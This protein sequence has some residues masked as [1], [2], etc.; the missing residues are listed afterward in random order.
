MRY[1]RATLLLTLLLSVTCG[2]EDEFGA[3]LL[4]FHVSYNQFFREYFGC[5]KE[6]VTLETCN[7]SKGI[8]NYKLL[9]QVSKKSELFK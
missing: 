6:A 7:T 9:Q 3:K 1:L 5:P 8:I 4:D 2:Q